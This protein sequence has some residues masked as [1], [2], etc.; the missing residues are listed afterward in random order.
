[1]SIKHVQPYTAADITTRRTAQ[2]R[3]AAHAILADAQRGPA[4][5]TAVEQHIAGLGRAQLANV[6]QM[7]FDE[8]AQHR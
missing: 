8:L 6:V 4:M 7:L 1:M 5:A 3:K 2:A